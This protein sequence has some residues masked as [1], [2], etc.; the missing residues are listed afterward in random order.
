MPEVDPQ[1]SAPSAS[2]S[3]SSPGPRVN[4]RR[5]V[6]KGNTRT[7]DEVLR[8]EMR[9]FEGAGTRRP[10]STAPRSACSAWATSKR[11]KSRTSR[12]PA[13]TTRSTWS[14]PSR[15]PPRAASCSAWATRSC[16]GVNLSVQLQENNFLGT[17]NRVSIAASS[18]SYQ[19]RYD[20][21]FT[22]PVLHRRRPVAGLQPLV[23]RVRLQRLQ[24]RQ[25]LD[26]QRRGAGLPWPAAQRVRHGL[27]AG[28]HRH[29]RDPA[30]RAPRRRR[31][32]TTSTRSGNRTFHAWRTQFGWARDTRNDYF[33]P[34]TAATTA[35]AAKSRCRARPSSTARP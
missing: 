14:T 28:R 20:F 6:F 33:M 18:S 25:L 30:L 3:R 10:R 16:P 29:Q 27:G 7:A 32:S 21:S 5:I 26:Q 11:S 13:A 35:P 8:R 24:R 34:S 23:A 15:K 31:S 12:S 9:Q 22:Q 2:T 4:V 1:T 17:G 19:K